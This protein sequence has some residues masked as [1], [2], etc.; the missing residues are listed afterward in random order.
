MNEHCLRDVLC[1]MRCSPELTE[2]RG[3]N[4]RNTALYQRSK[5]VLSPIIGKAP[6]QL[7]ILS[8]DVFMTYW[9]PKSKP[10]K[11][12]QSSTTLSRH[13]STR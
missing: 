1:P 6:K 10:N 7:N 12:D 11:L 2:G 3:V 5:C 8:H 4:E 13:A 9:P